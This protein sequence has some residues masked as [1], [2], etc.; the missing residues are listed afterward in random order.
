VDKEKILQKGDQRAVDV[1]LLRSPPDGVERLPEVEELAAAL[2]PAFYVDVG[3]VCNQKCSYCAVPR[4][5]QYRTSCGQARTLGLAAVS[6]GFSSAAFI[7][8]EPTIWPHLG[9]VLT[10]LREAGVERVTLT[11]NGLMLS[12]RAVLDELVGAGVTMIGLSLDDFDP[13]VQARLVRRDDNPELVQQALDNMAATGVESYVYS[14]VTSHLAGRAD[15]YVAGA[16]ATAR[17]FDKPP[18]FMVAGLKPVSEA[19]SNVDDI[20]LSLTDTAAEVKAVL[21]GLAG[22]VTASFRD[23]PLCLMRDHLKYSMDLFHE[24]AALDL[25]SGEMRVAP[26]AADRT[27]VEPCQDCQLRRWCPGIYRDYLKRYGSGEF[28]TIE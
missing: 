6:R 18:A 11:T 19:L 27:F 10:S 3:N 28:E 25:E 5:S 20:S 13:S 7:G 24:H 12:Y 21:A 2:A 8:G 26:L 17:A 23:I 9:E 22:R 15:D 1:R 4:D 16:L 14:V